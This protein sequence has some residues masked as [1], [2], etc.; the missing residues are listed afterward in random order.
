L[1]VLVNFIGLEFSSPFYSPADMNIVSTE[2]P[3]SIEEIK[4]TFAKKYLYKYKK[5]PEWIEMAV[6]GKFVFDITPNE[7][8]QKSIQSIIDDLNNFFNEFIQQNPEFF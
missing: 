4:W 7:E 5:P 2:I 6:L 3:L 8:V 1:T